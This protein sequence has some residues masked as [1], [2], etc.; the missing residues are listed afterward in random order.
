[1]EHPGHD[2]TRFQCL[3]LKFLY[4]WHFA[5]QRRQTPRK[6]SSLRLCFCNADISFT[7][8]RR[9]MALRKTAMEIMTL[10]LIRPGKLPSQVLKNVWVFEFREQHGS[11][12]EG[13]KPVKYCQHMYSLVTISCLCFLSSVY[14]QR[15]KK[16]PKYV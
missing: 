13:V 8:H 14:L 2:W 6:T 1:M 5:V 10:L 12:K 15:R 11:K 7:L 16:Y 4:S 3:I 9:L